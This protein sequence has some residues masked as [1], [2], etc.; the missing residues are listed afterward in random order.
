MIEVFIGN[1]GSETM[2][3]YNVIGQAVNECSRIE[4]ASVGGQVL[5]SYDTVQNANAAI[6]TD[7]KFTIQVKGISTPLK[8]YSVT[9]IGTPYSCNLAHHKLAG[10]FW[11][12]RLQ[13]TIQCIEDEL[14]TDQTLRGKI[15]LL[16]FDRNLRIELED[17]IE[18]DIPLYSDMEIYLETNRNTDTDTGDGKKPGNDVQATGCDRIYAKILKRSQG[19]I[20]VHITY[21]FEV[22]KKYTYPMY[23]YMNTYPWIIS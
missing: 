17:K 15:V 16:T 19:V 5:V 11:Q 7:G 3:R 18:P 12:G 10:F 2:M 9:G 20:E 22:I 13:C 21:G 6:K 23:P 14:V 8:V 1:F 4:G